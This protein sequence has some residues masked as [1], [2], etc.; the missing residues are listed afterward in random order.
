MFK[1]PEAFKGEDKYSY[2]LFR[3]ALE[4]GSNDNIKS[5]RIILRGAGCIRL[6]L[7]LVIVLTGC[8]EIYT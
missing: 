1:V 2:F 6:S 3:Y 4:G 7:R 5:I 8:R